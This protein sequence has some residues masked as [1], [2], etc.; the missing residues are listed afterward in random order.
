MIK[1]QTQKNPT[2][3]AF[4]QGFKV[5]DTLYGWLNGELYKLSPAF[6]KL[7]MNKHGSYKIIGNGRINAKKLH[8]ITEPIYF[9]HIDHENNRNAY[10][11]ALDKNG[12]VPGRIWRNMKEDL[13]KIKK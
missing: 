3:V 7:T 2:Q 8:Q 12:L 11:P 10:R 9:K 4:R 5:Y 13:I 1:K 6:Q